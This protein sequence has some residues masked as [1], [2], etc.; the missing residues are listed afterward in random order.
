MSSGVASRLRPSIISSEASFER[1][2]D[3]LRCH[4]GRGSGSHVGCQRYR[5]S[6]TCGGNDANDRLRAA[7]VKA[8]RQNSGRG[9]LLDR[10]TKRMPVLLGK[11]QYL[12]HPCFRL[13]MS[14]T[15]TLCDSVA[16]DVQHDP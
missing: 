7:P 10:T 1:P 12:L 6:L 4:L 9:N 11:A 13:L 8:P 15:A 5:K 14:I 16:V 3:T 2:C